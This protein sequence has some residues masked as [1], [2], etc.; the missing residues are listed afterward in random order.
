MPSKGFVKP[1]PVDRRLK[2]GL[3]AADYDAISLRANDVGTTAAAYVRQLIAIDLRR[4]EAPAKA[5]TD[6]TRLTLLADVH[7]LA[8]HVKRIAASVSMMARQVESG[9]VPITQPE[10]RVMQ[11]QVAD[12]M[13]RAAALFNKVLAR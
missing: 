1:E 9:R 7:L 5:R 12:A 6:R 3:T 10:M 11:A 4:D 2:V 8:M 13:D